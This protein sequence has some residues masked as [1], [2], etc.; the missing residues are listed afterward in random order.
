[1]HPGQ[2][3]Q[4]PLA[5]IGVRVGVGQEGGP[6]DGVQPVQLSDRWAVVNFSRGRGGNQGGH[7]GSCRSWTGLSS[8]TTRPAAACS[9]LWP[10]GE[11]F[12]QSVA[13]DDRQM[14]S[15]TQASITARGDREHHE[16]RI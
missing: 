7:N 3:G 11:T 12:T 6:L 15:S 9:H 4:V 13:Y 16:Y 10:G 1:Q 5:S 14:P 2:R 8:G